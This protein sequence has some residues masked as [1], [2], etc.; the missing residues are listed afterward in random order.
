MT[1]KLALFTAAALLCAAL[2]GCIVP[3]DSG[4]SSP[5]FPEETTQETAREMTVE[6][7]L[8]TA[9]ETTMETA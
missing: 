1:T 6:T 3:P 2:S 5:E 7:T 9:E 4:A 8:E